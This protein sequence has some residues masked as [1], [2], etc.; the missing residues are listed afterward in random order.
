M[1]TNEAITPVLDWF[2]SYDC[3]GGCPVE[4]GLEQISGKWKGLVIYHL[5][6]GT[7][8]FNALARA[9]GDVT[10]RSLTKQLRE[11]ERD[12]ILHREVFAEVPPR[13][14]YSLTKK[15]R[16]LQP[17]IG[18]LAVWG[19]SEALGATPVT[20]SAAPRQSE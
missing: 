14:E 12:G 10:Q 9:L 3:S 1:D 13:V 18:A 2:K 6:Q 15:G 8:R 5:L 4:A 20:A 19:Q 16:A 11:L 7:L 17:V